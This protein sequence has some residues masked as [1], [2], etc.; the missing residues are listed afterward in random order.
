MD[1]FQQKSGAGI[2][3]ASQKNKTS[4]VFLWWWSDF[5][6]LMFVKAVWTWKASV[7]QANQTLRCSSTTWALCY[8]QPR[9]WTWPRPLGFP[10]W[11]SV[12]ATQRIA[13]A[14]FAATL[15]LC[16]LLSCTLS[17]TFRK[18]FY[19]SVQVNHLYLCLWNQYRQRHH[20]TLI[21]FSWKWNIVL[22]KISGVIHFSNNT[23][24]DHSS[25]PPWGCHGT[26]WAAWTP[27]SPNASIPST[28]GSSKGLGFLSVPGT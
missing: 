6:K 14:V 10:T 5:M 27:I 12:R 23:N 13:I 26:C 8:S 15:C 28:L 2:I 21:S 1:Y 9:S 20:L 4:L 3:V 7:L 22:C 24:R 11:E 17:F 25:C 19:K 18:V 16:F